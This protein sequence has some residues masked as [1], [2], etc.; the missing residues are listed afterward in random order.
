MK[1]FGPFYCPKFNFPYSELFNN[2]ACRHDIDYRDQIGRYL[3]DRV[4]LYNMKRVCKDDLQLRY[5][6]L[7]YWLVRTFGRISYLYCKFKKWKNY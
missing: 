6:Y 3:A 5:A 1:C 4:F 2:A 7:Y